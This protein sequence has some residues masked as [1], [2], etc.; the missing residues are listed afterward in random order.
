MIITE[1]GTFGPATFPSKYID[2]IVCQYRIVAPSRHHQIKLTFLY[3]DIQSSKCYLDYVAVYNGTQI[4]PGNQLRLFCN[5]NDG[6]PV[7]TSTEPLMIVVFAG[8]TPK[9]YRGFHAS[10]QFLQ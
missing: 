3:M 4:N 5:N 6:D 1:E 7:V 10:V 8:N 2:P 9:K